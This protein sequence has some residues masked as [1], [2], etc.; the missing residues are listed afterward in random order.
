M[1]EHRHEKMMLH[2]TFMD[3]SKVLL[4]NGVTLNKS[5]QCDENLSAMRYT[6]HLA[7]LAHMESAAIP[8][9]REH[10]GSSIEARTVAIQ[11]VLENYTSDVAEGMVRYR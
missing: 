4:E 10:E 3:L 9:L 2:A 7:Q 8:K 5:G 1:A 6:I 11:N